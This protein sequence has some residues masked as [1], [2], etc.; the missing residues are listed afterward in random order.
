MLTVKKYTKEGFVAITQLG[1]AYFYAIL[2]IFLLTTNKKTI[3]LHLTL[4]LLACY[5][6][7]IIF[8]LF[9]FKNRPEKEDYFNLFTKINASSFP[10]VHMMTSIYVAVAL[11]NYIK[12]LPV[13]IFLGLTALLIGYSRI[14]L[15]KHY[16]IDVFFGLVI[17]LTLGIIYSFWFYA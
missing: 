10:S 5:I 4:G 14:Y 15:K 16:F 3:A 17:G 12:I 1:S 7:S 6:L 13:S 8:R 2:V 11:A 9:Y